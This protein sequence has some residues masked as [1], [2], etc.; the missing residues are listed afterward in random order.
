M[1]ASHFASSDLIWAEIAKSVR[2]A[3]TR[4]EAAFDLDPTT[5]A[6]AVAVVLDGLTLHVVLE[7]RTM[8]TDRAVTI[9]RRELGRLFSP[10]PKE[11]T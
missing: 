3:Q 11:P 2:V 7:P 8:T 1:L 5:E 6:I 4:G 10:A 9:L